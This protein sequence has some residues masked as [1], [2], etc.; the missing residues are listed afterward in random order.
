M[1]RLTDSGSSL[2]WHR[3]FGIGENALSRP[4]NR[5]LKVIREVVDIDQERFR[6]QRSINVQITER[7]ILTRQW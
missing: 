4:S 5:R 6:I 2:A 1:R 3:L 7:V